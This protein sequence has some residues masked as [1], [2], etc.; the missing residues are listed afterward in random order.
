M[1]F[2]SLVALVLFHSDV[3]SQSVMENTQMRFFTDEAFSSAKDITSK[4]TNTIEVGDIEMLITA[5]VTERI[6]VLSEIIFSFD[7]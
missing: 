7:Q 6:S 5:Q 4:R 1:L 2:I 3:F